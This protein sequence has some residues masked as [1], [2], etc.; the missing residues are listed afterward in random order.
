[1]VEREWRIFGRLDFEL[2]QVSRAIFPERFIKHFRQD[3]PGLL[4]RDN[5]FLG[6]GH[7][8]GSALPG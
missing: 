8:G 7:P 1:M 5:L 3:L 4:R 2:T 6:P